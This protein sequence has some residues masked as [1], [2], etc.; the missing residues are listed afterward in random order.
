MEKF[1][2]YKVPVAKITLTI[3]NQEVTLQGR[4]AERAIAKQYRV[5]KQMKTIKK[6]LTLK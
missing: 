3:N 4:A 2:P 5:L 1:K 6:C